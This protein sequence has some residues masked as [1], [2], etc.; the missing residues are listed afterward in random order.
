M[1]DE[2]GERVVVHICFVEDI[3]D[4]RGEV[5]FLVFDLDEHSLFVDVDI[6]DEAVFVFN[7]LELLLLV[8]FDVLVIVLEE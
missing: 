3:H 5:S 1:L 2:V 7:P 4:E 8:D 6:L